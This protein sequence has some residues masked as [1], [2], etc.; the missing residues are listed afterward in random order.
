MIGTDTD[1][2]SHEALAQA[3]Q[4]GDAVALHA[5]VVRH[6]APLFGFLY[7]LTGGDRALA[8]DLIQETM[9]RLLRGMGSYDGQRPFKPWL[10]Q[11]GVN[12][13]RDYYK[14]AEMRHTTSD[15]GEIRLM[16]APERPE[17]AVIQ[18]QTIQAAV[19]AVAHL[20]PHQ[21]EALMLRYVEELSLAE[22]ADILDI[23]EGTV[24]SR[25]S[26]ALK[27]LRAVMTEAWSGT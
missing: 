13:A 6:H 17:T 20:P 22:I 27:Q 2:L 25:L 21:R 14:Q 19:T 7:R 12:V 18:Q 10:Y 11:I 16:T 4:Q 24:K 5:L 26:L 9:V 3:V 15:N 8:E 23:P 1:N